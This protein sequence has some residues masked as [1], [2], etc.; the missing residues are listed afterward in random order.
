MKVRVTAYDLFGEIY[1]SRELDDYPAHYKWTGV[2]L[3]DGEILCMPS[4]VAEPVEKPDNF[5]GAAY[6]GM[7]PY[8][9]M[10]ISGNGRVIREWEALSMPSSVQQWCSFITDQGK[11]WILGNYHLKKKPL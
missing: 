5:Y 7:Q 10:L 3:P 4:I 2:V 6:T 9:V 11:A 8:T 1:L